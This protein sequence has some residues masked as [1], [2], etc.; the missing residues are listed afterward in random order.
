M[1]NS[2]SIKL[3]ILGLPVIH[4]LDEFA[5]LSKITKKWIFQFSI[6]SER[7][8]KEFSIPKKNGKLR[9]IAQPNKNLK[10]LQHWILV[11]IL[12]K[13]KVSESCKGF[14][15]KSSTLD[16]VIPHKEANTIMILDLKDFFTSVNA[17]QVYSIFKSIGYNNLIATVLTNC[18][19]FNGYLPQGSP[20]SPKLANLTAMK[21][22]LRIQGFVRK[23]AINFTRYADDLSFSGRSPSKITKIKPLIKYIIENE[24]FELNN[25]KTR[26]AGISRQKKITGIVISEFKIGIGKQKFKQI[27]S[28]IYHLI[29]PNEQNNTKLVS[30]VRGWLSY[31]NSVDKSALQKA[32]NY[33]LDLS[34]QYPNTII[35]QL[36]N[37]KEAELLKKTRQETTY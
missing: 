20:C 30:E 25:A 34:T 16:N 7:F 14:E 2:E 8:Y 15:K 29:L 22:D 31:L 11:Q 24:G 13:L 19:T 33:I 12:E 1:K 36:L 5:L 10:V 28:K 35:K 21:L 3:S 9:A 26:I 27:R 4:N 6:H 37:K 18:C 32:K 17:V 23:R